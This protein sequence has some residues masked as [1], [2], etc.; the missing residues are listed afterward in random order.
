MFT[1]LTALAR[2]VKCTYSVTMR[3]AGLLTLTS[4]ASAGAIG[5]VLRWHPP[6]VGSTEIVKT[7]NAK[8]R[9]I[10][11]LRGGRKRG[12][13]RKE[14]YIQPWSWAAIRKP[15]ERRLLDGLVQC[16]HF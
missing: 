13:T 2:R 8:L 9:T 3:L 10:R 1:V 15:A 11:C 14:G 5:G 7:T 16:A 6:T 4:C 12:K